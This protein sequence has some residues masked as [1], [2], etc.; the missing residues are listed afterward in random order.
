MAPAAQRTT[1]FACMG[2]SS[3]VAVAIWWACF[4]LIAPLPGLADTPDR[5]IFGVKCIA[6]A[7]LF[8]VVL[9][10]EAVA[11]ERLFSPAI[12]PLAGAETPRMRVNQRF[13]QNSVEQLLVF[14]PGLLLLAFYSD[15]GGMRAVIAATMVWIVGRIAFWIGYHKGPRFRAIGLFPM[16]QSLLILLW[17]AARFGDEVAGTPGTVALVAAFL[18]AEA[19]LTWLALRPAPA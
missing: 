10:A 13:L 5:L 17:A 7:V 18:L 6:V 16:V 11:H 3:A 14:A 8:S 1:I 15:A 12:D 19:W 9:G 4:H 2:V